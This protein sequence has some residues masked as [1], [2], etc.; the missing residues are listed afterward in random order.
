MSLGPNNGFSVRAQR[1]LVRVLLALR[2]EARRSPDPAFDAMRAEELADR[3]M[4]ELPRRVL[5]VGLCALALVAVV[6]LIPIARDY[7]PRGEAK[8]SVAQVVE[9]SIREQGAAVNAGL[10]AL[11][12]VVAP[13]AGDAASESDEGE[14]PAPEGAVAVAPFKRS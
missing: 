10:G 14:A 6:C 11:R 3:I 7:M 8:A 9:S 5:P 4:R 13:F 2:C 1:V 12:A